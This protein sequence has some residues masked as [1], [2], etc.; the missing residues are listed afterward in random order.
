[1]MFWGCISLPVCWSIYQ[2]NVQVFKGY[3]FQISIF[4]GIVK[5]SSPNSNLPKWSKL[6][7][8]WV[9]RSTVCQYRHVRATNVSISKLNY[10]G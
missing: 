1:M 4:L 5:L 10:F 6:I 3:I 7:L 8:L 9:Q 2:Q